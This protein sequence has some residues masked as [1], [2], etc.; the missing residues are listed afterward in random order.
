MAMMAINIKPGDEVITS[1]F[2]FISAV[3]MIC[4]LKAKPVF[5]DI[6]DKTFNIDASELEKKITKFESTVQ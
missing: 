4:L 6:C 1:P 3:E 2:S 5:I